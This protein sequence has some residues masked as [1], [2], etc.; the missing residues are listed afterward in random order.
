MSEHH[1]RRP[2]GRK[3][4]P[5]QAEGRRTARKLKRRNALAT[6]RHA[7]RRR[8]G[9]RVTVANLPIGDLPTVVCHVAQRGL[10]SA[11]GGDGGRWAGGELQR[12]TPS[13]RHDERCGAAVGSAQEQTV[14]EVGAAL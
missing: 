6:K 11:N 3:E 10:E 8:V 4:D 14:G 7:T 2:D 9:V 1:A 12:R 5:L 13:R